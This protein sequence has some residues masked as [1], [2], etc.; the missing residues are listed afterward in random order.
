MRLLVACPK[1]QLQ[2]DATGRKPGSRFRCRCGA[3]VTVQQPK[4]H[5]A[6]V[7]RCSACGA[8]R[9]EGSRTCQFCGADFTLHER[10]LDTVC[11]H[12]MALVSG[13]AKFCHHCGTALVPELVAGDQT[14]LD[15]PACG[16]PH[17][18]TSRRIGDV[19]VLECERCAGLW[20]GNDVFENLAERASSDAAEI[21]RYFVSPQARPAKVDSPEERASQ[22]WQYRHCP[23]CREMMY[24]RNYGRRSGVI[25]DLCKDHGVWFD[26]DELPR[27]L[28]WIRS[29]GMAKV[30]EER[31][32][33]A[34]REERVKRAT[35]PQPKRYPIMG[36]PFGDPDGEPDVTFGDFIGELVYWLFRVR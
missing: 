21:D 9:A 33:Q 7:V 8:P 15:C 1:C 22:Q 12:C 17:Q 14:K 19:T 2:Y 36:S 11:P 3:V 16:D 25:I 30:E 24:R 4:G 34:A 18:L 6:T 35:I 20:L 28:A 13:R 23:V 10:D 26:A 5:D 32:A 27:I 29:G 31:A